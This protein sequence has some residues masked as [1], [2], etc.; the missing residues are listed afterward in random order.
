MRF[1][2]GVTGFGELSE[3]I[4]SVTAVGQ[5]VVPGW[6]YAMTCSVSVLAVRLGLNGFDVLPKELSTQVL[7]VTG[8]TVDLVVSACGRQ[9]LEGLTRPV[10]GTPRN[11]GKTLGMLSVPTAANCTGAW[12]GPTRIAI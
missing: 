1:E 9:T 7:I 8:M 4:V 5:C 12:H 11:S 3:D 2:M 6:K 10:A